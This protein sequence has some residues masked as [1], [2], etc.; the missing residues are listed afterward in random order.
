[1]DISSGSVECEGLIMQGHFPS[2]ESSRHPF[3]L[4][5]A[6][7]YPV[8]NECHTLSMN[9]TMGLLT[10]ETVLQQC[11]LHRIIPEEIILEDVISEE[12]IPQYLGSLFHCNGFL[13]P[14]RSLIPSGQQ[15]VG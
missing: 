11:D 13:G 7:L 3:G 9:H 14:G 4:S 5:V 2:K 15:I 10:Q 12:V 8:T 1:M 6:L